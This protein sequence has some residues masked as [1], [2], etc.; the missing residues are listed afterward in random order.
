MNGQY[1]IGDIL[2]EN[3]TLTK[4]IGEGAF[5]RVYEAERDDYGKTYKAAIKIITIPQ[6]QSEVISVM[7]DGMGE[8]SVA[9]YFKGL[10]SELIDE[11]SLMSELKGNSNVVSY[12]DHTI[13]Q[14][15]EGIGWDIIIRME[16]LTPLL[17]YAREVEFTRK[18]IIQ[19]GI[20]MCHALE[21]C[22]K[23]N[24]MHRDIKPENIFVSKSGDFKLGDFGIARTVE[25]TAGSL[26]KKGTYTYMA[27]EIYKGDSYNSSV[28]IYSLGIVLY[29]M[30]NDNR[31]PF[32][33]AYPAPI[34]H[35]DR[36]NA[37]TKRISS[38]VLPP[39][40]NADGRL[41][42][43]VLKAC[44]HDP[45]ERYSSPMLMR[46]ELEAIMYK[47]GEASLIYPHGD[48]TPVRSIEYIDSSSP[49][50]DENVTVISSEQDIMTVIHD[51]KTENDTGKEDKEKKIKRRF[52]GIALGITFAAIIA[53]MLLIFMFGGENEADSSDSLDDLIQVTYPEPESEPKP[54]SVPELEIEPEPEPEPEIDT[55]IDLEFDIQYIQLD[56]TIK[57][58]YLEKLLAAPYE[59]LEEVREYWDHYN[60]NNMDDL[61]LTGANL[62]DLNFDGIPE[63]LI[64]REYLAS[65]GGSTLIVYTFNNDI[66]EEV[67]TLFFFYIPTI[68]LFQNLEN[69]T[70]SFFYIER[71]H[72]ENSITEDYDGG[73]STQEIIHKADN[74]TLMNNF[75]S[76]QKELYFQFFSSFDYGTNTF[77]RC[78][79]NDNY[80]IT[81][82]EFSDF[83]SAY[84]YSFDG[85]W[86]T[87]E[88]S[89]PGYKQIEIPQAIITRKPWGGDDPFNEADYIL[90]LDSYNAS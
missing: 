82:E 3:W 62:I 58:A 86:F 29:R 73:S 32:M 26:S 80:T 76:L 46:E 16:L 83:L 43:I 15:T 19:L 5:G 34:K 67:G 53:V 8:K 24:I 79:L 47:S 75:D 64:Y 31:V 78:T 61:H 69:G 87:G 28:D 84:G 25:K 57:H 77:S 38:A 37:L 30:L 17:I 13:I 66:L 4:Q 60:E 89:P 59:Y 1:N 20:D 10:V 71:D 52:A 51:D 2:L 14:F 7:A 65:A 56:A 44:A 18:D 22:Q 27:P 72:S 36:E 11:F 21:L 85:R 70:F 88:F 40:V 63:L 50:V 68:S 35:S 54:Q 12:E 81:V 90:F 42:E 6:T 74:L 39:P 55:G 33:P 9:E 49:R 45:K 41:A 23:Y 48:E